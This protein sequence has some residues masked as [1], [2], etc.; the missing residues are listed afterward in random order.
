M[1]KPLKNAQP[2]KPWHLKVENQG[3]RVEAGYR[4]KAF[5]SVMRNASQFHAGQIVVPF[6]GVAK[7]QRPQ[8]TTHYRRIIRCEDAKRAFLGCVHQSPFWGRPG[9]CSR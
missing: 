8:N 3:I 5:Q 1:A 6:P 9:G 2:I 7:K 4:L